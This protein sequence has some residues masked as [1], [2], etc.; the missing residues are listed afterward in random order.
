MVVDG[1]GSLFPVQMRDKARNQGSVDGDRWI[2]RS[3]GGFHVRLPELCWEAHGF[4]PQR[5]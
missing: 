5:S 4:L 2:D 1:E 3:D